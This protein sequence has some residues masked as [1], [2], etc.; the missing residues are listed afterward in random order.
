MRFIEALKILV[1]SSVG[2]AIGACAFDQETGDIATRTQNLTST[3][4]RVLGFE[5][6]ASDWSSTSGAISASSNAS[7]GTTALSWTA[8]GYTQITSIRIDAPGLAK[9]TASYDLRLPTT[10]GWGTAGLVAKVPSLGIH[11]S[12][13]GTVNLGGMPSGTY[14][15]INF[16]VPGN[17]Q[18]ALNSGATDITFVVVLNAQAGSGN[19]LVDN[20]SV[21][22]VSSGGSGG[23]GGNGGGSGGG[24]T[25]GETFS[26]SVP[27]GAD[28]DE[29]LLS[30]TQQMTID[31]R[32]VLGEAGKLSTVS[33]GG[34]AESDFASAVRGY[35]NII[36]QGHVD[37]MSQ[38]HIYGDITTGGIVKRQDGSVLVDGVTTQGATI[39]ADVSEWQVEWPIGTGTSVQRLAN[40]PPI[41]LEPGHYGSISIHTNSAVS[42]RTGRYFVDSFV[43]EP[44][45]ILNVDTSAGPVEIYVRNT[46]R[47]NIKLTYKAGPSG[48]VLFGYLGT[49]APV[50]QE[51]IVATVVAPN[52]TIE[53]RRPADNAPHQGA[54][55]GK[56]VH[57][58]S[59]ATIRHL[60]FDLGVITGDPCPSDE[61]DYDGDDIDDG[62]EACWY[63]AIKTD[64]GVCGCLTPDID[65]DGDLVMD[66][67]D[68]CRND[69]NNSTRGDCGCSGEA[70]VAPLGTECTDSVSFGKTICDG[71]GSCVPVEDDGTPGANDG[72]PPEDGC[73]LVTQDR[74]S[75]HVCPV[76]DG[77]KTYDAAVALC[78]RS[79]GR[80]L[81]EIDSTEENAFAATLVSGPAWIGGTDRTTE[82]EWFWMD[83]S[84]NNGTQFWTGGAGGR[85]HK[86]RYANWASGKPANDNAKN[87]AT[88]GPDG[89]WRGEN[90]SVAHHYICEGSFGSTR[91][92]GGDCSD[93]GGG[94]GD[95]DTGTGGTGGD[96]DGDGGRRPLDICEIVP[97][98]G[99]AGDGAG[100]TPVSDIPEEDCVPIPVDVS[101]PD[102]LRLW[103]EQGNLDN[104]ECDVHCGDDADDQWSE[105]QCEAQCSGEA[106]VPPA[107]ARCSAMGAPL[108]TLDIIDVGTCEVGDLRDSTPE[109]FLAAQDCSATKILG[110]DTR[111]GVKSKCLSMDAAFEP[112]SCSDDTDCIGQCD[113][114]D[115]NAHCCD[116][117]LGFCIDP[118]ITTSCQVDSYIDLRDDDQNCLGRC[119][120]VVG[121]GLDYEDIFPFYFPS[122]PEERCSEVRY[123]AINPAFDEG[124]VDGSLGF[125]PKAITEADLPDESEAPE[126]EYSN[127]FTELCPRGLGEQCGVCF[128]DGDPPPQCV[129]QNRHGW[130]TNN[131]SQKGVLPGNAAIEDA[132][133]G[134]RGNDKSLVTIDVDPL[135]TMDFDLEPLA[136]GA[137][138]FGLKAA[139]GI[140][141]K[142]QFSLGKINGK[143]DIFDVRAEL[144]AD[145]CGVST[146]ESRL[147]VLGLDFLPMVPGADTFLFDTDDIAAPAEGEDGFSRQRCL[148]AVDEYVEAFDRAK[149]A[150]RDAQELIT[151]YQALP[152]GA[153]FEP[154]F[155]ETLAGEGLRPL[156]MNG[157]CELEQPHETINAFIDYYQIYTIGLV[158]D[159]VT[160]L[161]SRV[162]SSSVLTDVLA[163]RDDVESTAQDYAGQRGYQFYAELGGVKDKQTVT[164]ISLRFFIGPIPAFLEVSAYLE[165]GMTGGFGVELSPGKL[166]NGGGTFA[167]AA[168]IATPYANSGV[169][170]FAGAGFNVGPLA[171]QIG[172]EGGITLANVRL[173]ATVSAGLAMEKTEDTE[174]ELPEDL[175]SLVDGAG[176]AYPRG[177]AAFQKYDFKFNY[178]YGVSLSLTD[179]LSGYVDGAIKVK[180]FFFS[181]KWSQRIVSFASPL[182]FPDVKLINGGAEADVGI[183]LPLWKNTF[184]SV[185]LVNLKKLKAPVISV[186]AV[187]PVGGS[188]LATT[189]PF[190]FSR[191]DDLYY[192]TLCTCVEEADA[193][194]RDADCCDG[195]TCNGEEGAKTCG[196][197]VCQE[198]GQLCN[199]YAP[200]GE[201][202]ACCGDLE[203]EYWGSGLSY[204]QAP[205]IIIDPPVIK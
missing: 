91:C 158:R 105:A 82:G 113:P 79:P 171:L 125:E 159:A 65:T 66:C 95:G 69:P 143:I 43:F 14:R 85:R 181:K 156:G 153:T 3:Q 81:I 131:P 29:L 97:F 175:A 140:L 94:D 17:V 46:L 184:E 63:S 68:E 177:G 152:E 134:A 132:G 61:C 33:S 70:D 106:I 90:C 100:Q 190:D 155:C 116:L 1:L 24:S 111:C 199:G 49:S 45:S 67:K 157:S 11:W 149:K 168:A 200:P 202:E 141:A 38:A 40:S 176:I 83:S 188:A 71:Q 169:T 162:L 114:N 120:S 121:C 25:T 130:C 186:P 18:A 205:E 32:C 107:N 75:Y 195:L 133:Q 119:S 160:N 147:E 179:M 13:L 115:A 21:S 86:S 47:L 53:L 170:L 15:T 51:A 72:D 150:L 77:G 194:S 39:S 178:E 78:D 80:H 148:A 167:E 193:C 30:T 87:C 52:S 23:T 117:E 118:R 138:K 31:S 144:S 165:Y 187:P 26:F 2:L 92:P 50:F 10:L 22:E 42:L 20:L 142:A 103:Q 128:I 6:P 93:T 96:G 191:V 110:Q 192:D 198:E 16:N 174:R 166:I 135:A 4:S 189:V 8:A 136:G 145:L 146:K 137:S 28:V 124:L 173:P 60:P 37:L 126:P 197:I 183:D 139:A 204:C 180:F 5:S 73:L 109:A 56:G 104:E 64:A 203:C 151:Q 88:I 35:T 101:D 74:R 41:T 59:N 201:A 57:C 48:H 27:R 102:A 98:C 112:T 185:P 108:A 12:D 54:F 34:P 123:C 62:D 99:I 19:F 164:I 129:R 172:I 127:D 76:G 89:L 122:D 9:S 161:A 163:A 55:F 58:N 196:T 44:W 84:L 7:Q 36:S 154:D 182:Q